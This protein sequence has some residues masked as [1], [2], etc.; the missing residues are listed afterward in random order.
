M[1]GS[2]VT[3]LVNQSTSNSKDQLFFLKPFVAPSRLGPLDI[4]CFPFLCFL[5]G[6]EYTKYQCLF[7]LNSVTC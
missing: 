3:V 4:F 2:K 6:C 7:F 1:L 5:S